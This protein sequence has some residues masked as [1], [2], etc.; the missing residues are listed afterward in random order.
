MES[1][2]PHICIKEIIVLFTFIVYKLI[3]VDITRVPGDWEYAIIF[4]MYKVRLHGNL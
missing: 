2:L 4:I 1:G 3:C